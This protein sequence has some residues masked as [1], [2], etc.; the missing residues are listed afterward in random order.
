MDKGTN[1]LDV[2]E[3]RSYRLQH[4]WVGIVN[5]SQA[6]INRNVDMIVARRKEREYFATSPDYGHLSSKM[7]SEYLAKLLSKHLE[8]VIRARIPSITS[9]INKSVEE[10]ESEMDHLGRPIAVD[11]GEH[12]DG[13]RPGGDIYGVFDNQLPAALRKLPFDRHL[14]IQ[15]VRKVVSEADGYQPHLIAPEQGVEAL[16]DSVSGDSCCCKCVL[17]KV[18]G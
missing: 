7:G 9:L 12:L 16:S 10:L 3:G 4:P 8:S 6:D 14:S 11:A 5:R 1:A 2:L 15:N 18:P 13:G 17:G